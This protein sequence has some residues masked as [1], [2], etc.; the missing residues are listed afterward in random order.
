MDAKARSLTFMG[1]A[2]LLRV[3]FFQRQYVWTR[4]NWEELLNDLLNTKKTHFLGALILKQQDTLSGEAK[5]TLVID[6]QQ[7]LTTLS[8]L[9]KAAYDSLPEDVKADLTAPVRMY[10]FHKKQHTDKQYLVRI[11]HSHV[12]SKPYENVIRS[13]I[14]PKDVLSSPLGQSRVEECYAYFCGELAKRC[15]EDRKALFNR[16]L[17]PEYKIIVVID[18]SK[19]DNEQAIFDTINSA[20]V[21]LSSSDIIKNALFQR[22]IQLFGQEKAIE[23]Y[24]E[25]WKGV[26]LQD[27]ETIRYWESER[28]TGRLR[29]DNI[30]ILLHCIAVIQGFYDPDTD[31]LSDL[32]VLYKKQ[33]QALAEEA[34]LSFVDDIH[35]YALIYR[36]R[37]LSFDRTTQFGFADGSK[38]LLHILETLQVSTFHPFILFVYKSQSQ[39]VMTSTLSLLEKFVLRRAITGQETKSYNKLCKE[40]IN[41]PH[42]LSVRL[43]ESPDDKV[44]TGLCRIDNKEA[45]LV[46]FWLELLRRNKDAK[47]DTSELKFAYS[48]EH[49]MPQAWQQYWGDLPKKHNPDGTEVSQEELARDRSEKVGW[50][51]NMTLLTTHLNSSLRNAAFDKKVNGAGRMKGMKS[52]SDLSI[53][54]DDVISHYEQGRNWD[55]ER[56][57]ERTKNLFE[58]FKQIWGM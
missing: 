32:A 44:I 50:I 5:E 38:R 56:I 1:E 42:Q 14:D 52:Y 13:G 53:T 19:E 18:L 4:D 28:L 17:D 45:A 24:N 47:Y 34:L 6:G 31:N 55:E 48:L 3:P 25:K 51:G 22:A 30:E 15:E 43:Q 16:L 10:L 37:I 39:E 41:N 29:R 8:I 23:L 46:L 27:Q 58:E 33:I 20:G 7:R 26:F 12:D 54:K 35:R 9:L 49:I 57:V 40:F 21:R 11:A 36:E 2:G